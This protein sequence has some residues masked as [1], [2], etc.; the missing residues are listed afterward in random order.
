M[1]AFDTQSA[2]LQHDRYSV[3]NSIRS[4][5]VAE[6]I[7]GLSRC[8]SAT[9]QASHCFVLLDPSLRDPKAD[10]DH[11]DCFREK[12]KILVRV[13]HPRFTSRFRP[14]LIELDLNRA[15]DVFLLEASFSLSLQD[16]QPNQAARG[17]GHRIG[18]WLISS[19][20]AADVAA[21]LARIGLVRD[22]QNGQ[23]WLRLNDPRALDIIWHECNP[24]QRTAMLGPIDEWTFLARDIRL[25][26][27]AS[28]E[29][30]IEKSRRL[31]FDIASWSRIDAAGC[32]NQALLQWQRKTGR[33]QSAVALHVAAKAVA[34]AA[35]Y[36]INDYVDLTAF[37]FHALAIHPTFD[38]HPLLQK[39]L[40]KIKA[41]NIFYSE[42]A[43]DITE[44]Q[45]NIIRT[46]ALS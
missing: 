29:P 5:T 42:L 33:V 3:E 30:R 8:S 2:V 31:R 39:Q 7:D 28:G 24:D 46:T 43:A 37:A 38:S 1:Q 14:A 16:W 35:A 15:R 34:R 21:H 27:L 36:G 9:R 22:E 40:S 6:L 4:S 12:P 11:G 20:S 23:R 41:E 44:E 10:P 19:Q 13:D 17:L 45:W 18:G 25:Q 26:R 32:L